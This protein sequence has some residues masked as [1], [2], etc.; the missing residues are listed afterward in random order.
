MSLPLTGAGPSKGSPFP[1]EVNFD[2]DETA[3]FDGGWSEVGGNVLNDK[4]AL[5]S[6]LV[7]NGDFANWTLDDPDGWT[8]IGEAGADPELSEVGAGQGHGGAGNGLAN[9]FNSAS[10]VDPRLLQI[11]LT[12]GDWYEITLDIDTVVVGGVKVGD[13]NLGISFTTYLTTGS[14]AQRGRGK[15]TQTFIG[16]QGIGTDTT[17]D[18]VSYKKLTLTSLL[19]ALK[20]QFGLSDGFFIDVAI[21]AATALSPIGII[22]NL[23]DP[24]TPANFGMAYMDGTNLIVDKNVAG[25]YS[26]LASVAQAVTQD[27]ILRI[28]NP[29]DSNVLDILYNGVSKA[30]PTISDAGIISNT[31]IALFS[32][33]AN[34]A[35]SKVTIGLL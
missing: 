15:S 13:N 10:S 3:F 29:V 8:V 16:S 27:Q 5:G 21:N 17:I 12:V 35:I 32:T 34:N 14:K 9:F 24:A 18:N 6:E 31:G 30:T 7:V 20:A 19:N 25:T 23:D 22:W 1:I 11:I 28:E 33:E 2:G 26:N 4:I